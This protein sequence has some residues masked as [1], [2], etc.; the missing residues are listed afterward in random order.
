MTFS[1]KKANE[2]REKFEQENGI[3]FDCV[4]RARFEAK[5]LQPGSTN[6]N[7]DAKFLVSDY[8]FNN[9]VYTSCTNV[10]IKYGMND[11]L[12]FSSSQNMSK[13][14]RVYDYM[15]ELSLIEG[16]TPEKV[17]HHH[18]TK[19]NLQKHEQYVLVGF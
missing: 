6:Y 2:L 11:C 10:D 7:P 17:F 1:I 14:S 12:A 15:N 3:V 9:R 5:F 4:I 8:D 18:I 16:H 19:Q 13:Y